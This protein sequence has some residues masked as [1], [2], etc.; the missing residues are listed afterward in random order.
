MQFD[1]TLYLG[2]CGNRIML[3]NALPLLRVYT[4]LTDAVTGE[5]A[6]GEVEGVR[7]VQVL[8]SVS[9]TCPSSDEKTSGS[10]T[11]A[12]RAAP[13]ETARQRGAR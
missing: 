10:T 11:V 13:G 2:L 12:R 8:R 4:A 9:N 7:T 3:T 5:N 1:P 6:N